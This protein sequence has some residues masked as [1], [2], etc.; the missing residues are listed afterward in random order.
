MKRLILGVMIA[1]MA[2]PAFAKDIFGISK[3]MDASD[4]KQFVDK[5]EGSPKSTELFNMTK[6]PVSKKSYLYLEEPPKAHPLFRGYGVIVS[7]DDKV[8]GVSANNGFYVEEERTEE[9][10]YLTSLK[11]V[12]GDQFKSSEFITVAGLNPNVK[13]KWNITTWNKFDASEPKSFDNIETVKLAYISDSGGYAKQVEIFYL[14]EGIE[15]CLT[16]IG[17]L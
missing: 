17:G 15:Q 11:S 9:N 7:P 16:V 1:S 2:R 12:Y 4:L 8:C 3:G 10:I 5:G 14:F 13:I 6:L